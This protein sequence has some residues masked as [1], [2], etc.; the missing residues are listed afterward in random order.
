MSDEVV[1]DEFYK[2]IQKQS[3][4][5]NVTVDNGVKTLSVHYRAHKSCLWSMSSVRRTL[6]ASFNPISLTSM[7]WARG[8]E[9]GAR[10]TK[11]FFW[12]RRVIFY[13]FINGGISSRYFMLVL[14][15]E[16]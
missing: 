8:S 12:Y 13:I 10:V 11:V 16:K 5:N 6:P 15:G 4:F 14:A 3:Y 7:A 9:P 1:A 2:K